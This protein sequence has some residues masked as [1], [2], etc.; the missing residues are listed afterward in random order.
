MSNQDGMQH[1]DRGLEAA[2]RLYSEGRFEDAL[3]SLDEVI[4]GDPSDA[5]A[6]YLRGIILKDSNL[7]AQAVDAFDRAL[8]LEPGLERAYY[9]RGTARFLAG[10][11]DGALHDL[12]RAIEE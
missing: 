2:L 6:H 1:R 7:D 4:A 8:A 9:H 11:R 10:D 12:E 3:A 5:G